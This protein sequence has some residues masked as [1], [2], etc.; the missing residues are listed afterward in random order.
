[1]LGYF[2][3]SV[4]FPHTRRIEC[5]MCHLVSPFIFILNIDFCNNLVPNEVKTFVAYSI[6]VFS[7]RSQVTFHGLASLGLD[8][9]T[10]PVTCQMERVIKADWGLRCNY[11]KVQGRRSEIY[12]SESPP[13]QAACTSIRYR[14][15]RTR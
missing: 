8:C 6:G 15:P 12:G 9:F 11:R 3:L 2:F 5:S 1:M 14:V 10:L 7:Y 13:A 4:N